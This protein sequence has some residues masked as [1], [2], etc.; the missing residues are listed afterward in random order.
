[1]SGSALLG[2]FRGIGNCGC[3]DSSWSFRN[4]ECPGFFFGCPGLFWVNSE[5]QEI[6]G[7]LILRLGC[8]DFTQEIVGV[9]ILRL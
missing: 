7:V 8:P 2:A 5:A 1:M 6:V 9:L 4:F 3:Q